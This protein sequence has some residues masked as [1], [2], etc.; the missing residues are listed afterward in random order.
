MND[1]KVFIPITKRNDDEQM[2]YG[3]AS[4]SDLDSQGDI[5][6]T[7]AMKGALDGYLRFPTIR[8]MHQAKAVGTTKEASVDANGLFIG[9]KIVD[10]DAWLKVKEGV[11]RAF[12]IGGRIMKRTAEIVDEMRLTEISL[13]DVPANEH[14]VITLFKAE[15]GKTMSINAELEKYM[16][17]LEV[18]KEEIDVKAKM[19]EEIMDASH[20]LSSAC[21]LCYTMD[22]F[23]YKGKPTEELMTAIKALKVLAVRLLTETEYVKFDAILST[24]KQNDGR[25][26]KHVYEF[27]KVQSGG[28]F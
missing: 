2:V 9:A 3:Y 16:D 5:V 18:K 26:A 22:W 14:A 20:I 17:E 21:E 6:S 23:E 12:S 19:A 1:T 8:E 4:T 11:Y 28:K 24:I 27:I 10:K 25:T 7:E 13:V 15:D